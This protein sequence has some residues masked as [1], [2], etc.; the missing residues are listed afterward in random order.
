MIRVLK[1]LVLAMLGLAL[2]PS[3]SQA[4]LTRFLHHGYGH[5]EMQTN[6]PL[7]ANRFVTEQHTGNRAVDKG[8]VHNV[9]RSNAAIS[10]ANR[11]TTPDASATRFA[12]PVRI[13]QHEAPVLNSHP[14]VTEIPVSDNI[15]RSTAMPQPHQ[16]IESPFRG[17]ERHGKMA[18]HSPRH[19]PFLKH[20]LSHPPRAVV[21]EASRE[22]V[23]KTPYS[24]GYFGASGSK[25]WHRHL[26]YRDRSIEWQYR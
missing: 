4:Q 22:P 24:Y 8:E 15:L 12:S 23:W 18:A 26:G 16:V 2:S 20:Q 19:P 9:D 11:R 3:T 21:Q 25:K 17:P 6:S 7:P 10:H 1:L 5:R 13:V 14:A